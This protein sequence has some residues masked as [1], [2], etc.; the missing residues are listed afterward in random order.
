MA[1]SNLAPTLSKPNG[2]F[3]YE[4]IPQG[5]MEAF[6]W[7][8]QFYGDLVIAQETIQNEKDTQQVKSSII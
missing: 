2:S 7:W 4:N 5:K 3:L 1:R 6:L 8:S